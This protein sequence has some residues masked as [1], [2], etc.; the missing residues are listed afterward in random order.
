M[1]FE[2]AEIIGEK[3]FFKYFWFLV[4]I[5]VGLYFASGI[6]SI[7]PGENGVIR[8]FGKLSAITGPG[9]HYHLPWPI[10]TLVKVKVSEIKRIEI[11]FRTIA[12]K[13]VAR[14]MDV[15]EES[16]MLTGD[17][18]IVSADFIVQYQIKDAANYIF[19]VDNVTATI[20]KASEA[21]MRQIAASHNID[22]ILTE[23]KDF[24]QLE[25]RELL[26]NILNK[27]EMGINIIAVKLQDVEPP[28]AVIDAFKSVASA[29]EDKEKY[30]NEAMGYKNDII[31]KAKGNAER[32]IQEAEAYSQEKINH[33]KGEAEKFLK[34]LSEYEKAPTITRTR[35]YIETMEKVL[36]KTKKVITDAKNTNDI[37]KLLNLNEGVK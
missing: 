31:P 15:P 4:L 19:K 33:A 27:Y 3:S 37:F 5:G 22:E 16:V 35:L 36:S 29:K 25:A 10:E 14:Y 11:G 32:I 6:Y 1:N 34:V 26:Q 7:D 13:P 21:T 17:A 12:V 18:N 20:K 8:R 30:I 9:L 28:E 24:I 23:K 2:D